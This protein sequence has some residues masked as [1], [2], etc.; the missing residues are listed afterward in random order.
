MD[1]ATFDAL[2]E[3]NPVLLATLAAWRVV[4][5]LAAAHPSDREWATAAK[6]LDDAIREALDVSADTLTDDDMRRHLIRHT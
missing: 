3:E 6:A 2:L 1:A 5:D 4:D